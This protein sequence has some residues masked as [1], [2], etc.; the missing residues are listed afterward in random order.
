M[1]SANIHMGA[2]AVQ[3]SEAKLL[4]SQLDASEAEQRQLVVSRSGQQC[5]AFLLASFVCGQL[6]LLSHQNHQAGCST[7]PS[8]VLGHGLG[9]AYIGWCTSSRLCWLLLLAASSPAPAPAP[10]EAGTNLGSLRS[11]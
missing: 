3:M 7:G 1:T 4:S 10:E 11:H 2:A 9:S 6:S 8:G 5:D